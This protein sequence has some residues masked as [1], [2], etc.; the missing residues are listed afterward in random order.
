MKVLIVYFS[1][2]GNTRRV[3]RDLQALLDCDIEGLEESRGRGG[4]LGWLRSGYEAIREKEPEIEE[5]EAKLGDYDLLIVGT[6]IWAGSL[7]SP[8][9][10]FLKDYAD[11]LPDMAAFTTMKGDE[12]KP[13]IEDMEAVTGKN[14][15]AKMG[16]ME[17]E[18]ESGEY[19]AKLREF[20]RDIPGL[21]ES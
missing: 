3:S 2:T 12:Y 15:V 13:V 18:I 1:R 21:G 14:F 20:V 19:M 7:A 8:V 5:V 4:P 6:P 17:E 16:V 11:S 10:S 9:R